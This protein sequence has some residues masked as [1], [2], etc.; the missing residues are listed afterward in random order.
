MNYKSLLLLLSIVSLNMLAQDRKTN[1]VPQLTSN[2]IKQVIA[3]MTLEE[4][5]SLLLGTNKKISNG[6][7]VG[8]S[9]GRIKGAAGYTMG[10]ERFGIPGT[11]LADGPAGVRIDPTRKDDTKTYYA[12][13]WPV[14]TLLASSWDTAL[15]EKVG[16]AF[17]KEVKDYGIDVILAPGLNIQ[18]DPLCGRNFEYYS[19]DPFVSGYIAAAIVK[20]IQ[21]NGVGTS[22]KH[23][24]VN[25]QESNR[26]KVNAIVSER[27]L[28]EIYLKGFEIAVKEG[29]PWT[30]MSSYNKLNGTYT[31]QRYDLLTQILRDEW[32]FKGY[33]MTD[34]FGGD[35]SVTQMKAGNDLIMPGGSSYYKKIV[36][37]VNN[38]TLDIKVLDKNVER[39]LN[40]IVQTPTFKNYNC[41]NTPDLKA[42]AI[43]A[44]EAASESMVLLKNNDN[45]LPL[46]NDTKIAVFGIA[47]YN[48]YVGGTGSGGVNMAYTVSFAD[49]M[50]NAGYRL[51]ENLETNY[52]KH[53]AQDKL[54]HP[55]KSLITIGMPRMIPEL[56]PTLD[57][58]EKSAIESDV[59]IFTI[60]RNAGEGA[61]RKI[62][63]N[64]DLS[65]IE[66]TL[67]K[68]IADAFHSKGKKLIVV[69]NIGGVI[70]TASWKDNSDAILLAWQP[71]QEAGNAFADVLRGIVNPSG[72]LATTFPMKYTDLP[73]SKNFPGF[74]ADRPIEHVY[75]D[76]IY[77]GYRYFNTF[78]V[79]TSFPFG[80]GLSYSSFDYSGLKLSSSTFKGVIKATVTITNTG[81]IAGKEV[82]QLYLS[83]PKK[84]IDKPVQ[85]LKG[86]AKTVLLTPGDS[87]TIT[88]TL[89]PRDLSSFIT[90]QTAW[91]AHAGQYKLNIATSSEDIK[92]S[93]TFKL[94][95]DLVVEKVNKALVP[96]STI[97]ELKSL[98]ATK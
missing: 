36:D 26:D 20:G 53:I 25:N 77:V 90:E 68:N 16:V 31:S 41:S 14:G 82:V 75:E 5:A 44:R 87:Q 22:I 32:G 94:P 81:K 93:K 64:F 97:N 86:F 23:F 34:W 91:I 40:V 83:A 3:A 18:K 6:P 29:H 88:F 71:G 56:S 2:N 38:G 10:I 80:Y 48:T 35:D 27:A 61:D 17:G 98:S 74:P 51:D 85:E 47:S 70:E 28:R 33:V 63:D 95:K 84:D 45:I 1:I 92:L 7:V 21:S 72:K 37:A 49:G 39:I 54:N 89:T 12:T 9:E 76:G 73:S 65:E 57:D 58:L 30:V 19:E 78:G 46:K 59:A 50:K 66:K 24:A 15:V 43:L 52:T 67:I 55:K 4:K 96:E 8:N 62:I 13:A 11:V 69:M 79:K 60:G 42:N